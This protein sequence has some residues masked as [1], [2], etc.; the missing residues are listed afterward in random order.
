MRIWLRGVFLLAICGSCDLWASYVSDTEASCNK[1][2]CPNGGVCNPTTGI[3]EGENVPG[4]GGD[5]APDGGG[6]KEFCAA[7]NGLV[8][9]YQFEG[10]S[11][12]QIPD[13]SGNGNDGVPA[14]VSFVPGQVGNAASFGATSFI[15]VKD[16]RTLDLE[17]GLT[18]EMWINPSILPPPSSSQRAGLF[19]ND[20]EYSLFLSSTGSLSC[21]ATANA[22]TP[23][24]TIVAGEWAHIACTWD[25]FTVRVY[26]NGHE[27]ASQPATGIL[28]IGSVVGSMIGA[29]SPSGDN[30]V[31]LID[32]MRIWKRALTQAELCADFGGGGC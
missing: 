6:D 29:N 7:L 27:V 13:E 3:C 18:I 2:G 26:K 1:R 23:A 24:G 17:K 15:G 30:F 28:P 20:G 9:C 16:S 10:I 5:M 8:A 31:G 21:D 14:N 22:I 11:N 4:D 25:T 32:Q 19:D 12:N